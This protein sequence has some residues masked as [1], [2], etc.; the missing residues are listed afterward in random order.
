[1]KQVSCVRCQ[2]NTPFVKNDKC[3]KEEGENAEDVGGGEWG[4]GAPLPIPNREVRA[5]YADGTAMQGGR[6]GSRLLL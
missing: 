2:P 5:T 3:R 6:V 1:M 4:G